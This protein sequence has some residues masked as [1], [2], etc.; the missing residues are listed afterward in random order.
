MALN[1]VSLINDYSS[2]SKVYQSVG[3]IQFDYTLPFLPE[4]KANL[5]L[6]Y[7]YNHGECWNYNYPFSPAA[8]KDGHYV[9]GSDSPVY[10]GYASKGKEN[11]ERYNLLLDFFLNYNKDF[12]AI[13]S[14]LDVTAGYSWQKFRDKQHNFSWVNAPGQSFDG[15]M[16][17]PVWYGSTPYQLVSFF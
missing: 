13:S 16:R 1:P 14:S 10:D 11:Q 4:L 8:W 9:A 3:N 17:S 2:T 15:Y 12:E 5:N 7:E 6:G